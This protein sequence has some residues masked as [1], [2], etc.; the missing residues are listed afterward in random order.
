M[1]Q[2]R[3]VARIAP[4]VH[5]AQAAQQAILDKN[6]RQLSRGCSVQLP[7]RCVLWRHDCALALLVLCRPRWEDR[8]RQVRNQLSSSFLEEVKQ[9]SCQELLLFSP[10]VA[11]CQSASDTFTSRDTAAWI[12]QRYSR[13]GTVVRF[14]P[15]TCPFPA[16]T[17]CTSSWARHFQL[18][19]RSMQHV[20]PVK[21]FPPGVKSCW[22][23]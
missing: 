19:A 7:K 4:R 13:G 21:A 2:A 3:D 22:D 11:A 1:W 16:L 20:L 17:R 10:P 12:V 18:L 6:G 23:P 8:V 14:L 9:C 5:S 15:S